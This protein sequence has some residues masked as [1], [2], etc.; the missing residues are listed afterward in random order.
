V[1]SFALL[2]SSLFLRFCSDPNNN[3]VVVWESGAILQY[4]QKHYDKQHKFETTTAQDEADLLSY[5]FLQV[6]G[7]GYFPLPLFLRLI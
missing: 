1:S 5:L 2:H 4:L 6:S 3:N 7:L